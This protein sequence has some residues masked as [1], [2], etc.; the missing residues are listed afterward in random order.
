MLASVYKK[1]RS[2]EILIVGFLLLFLTS[3][4]LET[5]RHEPTQAISDTN[6]FLKA[7]YLDEDYRKALEVADVHL[8]EST[9]P[10]DLKQMVGGIKQQW[11]KLNALK[12]DSYL[13]T[14]G[15]TMELFYV[16]TYEKGVLY[17]RLV[18][19]GDLSTGYKVSGVW[20]SPDPYPEQPLRRKLEKELQ[21]K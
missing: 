3:C 6:Q 18:L 8:R 17:H 2:Y 20:Y 19:G 7:L 12:A 15:R 14:P 1:G 5:F 11:G 16:G 4:R 13:M 21:V 9:S 10:D